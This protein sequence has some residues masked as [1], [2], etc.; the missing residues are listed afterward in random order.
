MNILLV[1]DEEPILRVIGDFLQDCGHEVVSAADGAE[2]LKILE[3]G[4]SC[5]LIVS[6]IRM[7][8]LD[9]L[10]FLRAARVRFPGIPVVLM[11]GHGDEQV[12]IAALQE[13]AHDYLKK[14]IR[15]NELIDRVDQV[16]ERR[17]LES[18]VQEDYQNLLRTRR[19]LGAQE[20]QQADPK[21]PG[22]EKGPAEFLVVAGDE[23]TRQ[24]VSGA[25]T[26]L[27]HHGEFTGSA[28]EGRA[29]FSER[30]FD[31]VISDVELP[32]MDG[33]EMIQRLRASDPTVIPVVLTSRGDRETLAR[34]LEGGVRGFLTRPFTAEEL[35]LRLE[36]AL[37]ERRQIV[38][39]RLLLGDLMRARSELREKVVERERYLSHLID[40]VPFGIIATDST[41]EIL[42]FSGRAEEMY[43]YTESEI[44]GRPWSVLS[45]EGQC[46]P[47]PAQSDGRSQVQAGHVRN[48]GKPFPVLIHSRDI[49]DD[50]G[51]R[52]AHLHVVEDRTE[53]EQVETQLLYAERLS[54][55]GQLAPRVAHELKTPLQVI[56]GQTELAQMALEDGKAQLIGE[57][58]AEIP[59]AVKNMVDLVHQMLNLGKPTESREEAIHLAEEMER[60]L[61]TLGN[62]GVVKYCEIFRDFAD[63]LPQIHGDRAQIEQVFRNLVVN[64]AQAMEDSER[65]DLTLRLWPSPDGGRVEARVCDTGPGIPPECRDRIF[66]PFF[67]TKSP[68]KGT[69]LGLP[70]VK[71]VLNRHRAT[72]EVESAVGEGTCFVL[73]FPAV[74]GSAE[75]SELPEASR[76]G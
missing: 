74:R 65:R 58:L 19:D 1:D 13:G 38:E 31:V 4:R 60:V 50:R 73:S 48:D 23:S 17:R 32:G 29:R 57:C 10:A 49:L 5:E 39:A 27:G 63:D 24:L 75:A 3:A 64:A 18:Q 16:E 9:G 15:L 7:P 2:A 59:A 53:R 70:I 34:A 62:L 71:T 55:L 76:S 46:G 68:G 8:R 26:D 25:L 37:Q 21:L 44:A 35:R 56:S 33:I 40:A 22:P 72:I 52:I 36:K 45:A 11:T 42:T 51:K 54:L 30:V 14:P 28:A 47:E 6:D 12:A 66:Q 69:G 61:T 67:T 41:G 20:D 43:G